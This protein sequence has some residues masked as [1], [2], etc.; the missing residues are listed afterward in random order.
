V[1]WERAVAENAWQ[2][3]DGIYR[4]LLPLP[5]AVPFVNAFLVESHS[6]YMLVDCGA[7]WL[8]SLRA[9]G[10]A[11]KAIGVPPRGLTSLVLTHRHP[12]HAAGAG[13]VH[14]RWGGRVLLHPL[15]R[16]QRRIESADLQAWLATHGVDEGILGKPPP[17]PREPVEAL[18]V[19]IDPLPMDESL[20]VGDLAFEIVHVPGHS[21]GQVMLREPRRGWLLTADHVL[22]PHAPNVWIFPGTDGDPLGEYLESLERIL[23]LD[24]SLILPGHGMPLR[25]NLRDLTRAVAD[26]HRAFAARVHSALRGKRLTTWEVVKLTRSEP[27]TDPAGA[28]FA[29]A[30][31]LAALTYLEKRGEVSQAEEGHWVATDSVSRQNSIPLSSVRRDT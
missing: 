27:P 24:A 3:D 29:L 30:E 23:D 1:T 2:I 9:L 4:I 6:Q 13:S 11:L 10:R 18:P 19:E 8:P 21:P 31:V 22:Q 26:F 15:E 28:R 20:I 16:E 5:W 14:Q 12:D 17:P 7:N 25:S